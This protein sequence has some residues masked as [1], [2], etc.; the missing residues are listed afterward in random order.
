[1]QDTV[2]P[3]LPSHSF[4]TLHSPRTLLSVSTLQDTLIPGLSSASVA[5][6]LQEHLGVDGSSLYSGR[7]LVG[8]Y[9]QQVGLLPGWYMQLV[10]HAPCM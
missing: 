7:E 3:C 9:M 8:W 4:S 1:M 10:V 6:Y 2:R 5:K